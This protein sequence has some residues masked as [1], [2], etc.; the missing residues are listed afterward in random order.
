MR[1]VRIA[2]LKAR[3]A[4]GLWLD[5]HEDTVPAI[6]K[7]TSKRLFRVQGL[8]SIAKHTSKLLFRV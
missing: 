5:G 6:A 1:L 3:S 2:V 7:H 8:G 4:D